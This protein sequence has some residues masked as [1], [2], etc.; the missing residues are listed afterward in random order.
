MTNVRSI[1]VYC[2]ESCYLENDNIDVM[3]LGGLSCETSQV[4]RLSRDIR[5]VKTRHG[6]PTSFEAKWTKVSPAKIDFYQDLVRLYLTEDGL[7]FRGLVVPTKSD[8]RH[9]EY[10]QSHDDWYYKMYYTLL[11]YIVS[12]PHQYQFYLDIKDTHGGERMAKLQEVLANKIHDHDRESIRRVQQI[13]SH[14]SEILQL[15]DILIGAI[16]YANRGLTTSTAKMSIINILKEDR[17]EDAL[18]KT[19]RFAAVKF[20]ILMWESQ[21]RKT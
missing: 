10:G 14:E 5:A 3:V 7:R 12:P 2:D 18:T 11:S 9:G 8:L 6:L 15:A 1:N 4:K 21:G 13:R 20:N 17:G 19:S 16:A